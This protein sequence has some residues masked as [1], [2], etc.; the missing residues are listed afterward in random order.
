MTIENQNGKA[1]LIN[2]IQTV[3]APSY[4]KKL[5]EDLILAALF[6]RE[7]EGIIAARGDKVKVNQLSLGPAETLSGDKTKFN[8]KPITVNQFELTINRQTV[9][10]C[11]ITNLALLQSQPFMEDLKNEMSFQLMLKMEQ[12]ILEDYIAGM[13]AGNILNPITASD[14]DT[15][16]VS[17]AR[18]KASRAKLPPAGR[19][20]VMS[21]EYYGDMLN[22]T[23]VL[24][25]DFV[26]GEAIRSGKVPS[27]YG[28]GML[29][30]QSLTT[31]TAMFF[32][33]SCLQLAMQQGLTFDIVSQ[34]SNNKLSWLLVADFVWDMK[35]FDNARA[36]YV[37]EA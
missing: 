25:S 35:I 24:S 6:E 27:I 31:D 10:S 1:D 2:L 36:W 9:H 8:S 23:P 30:S 32:H 33:K 15:K 16:D 22:K 34:K 12:E 7:Y 20:M 28:F 21:P 19:F 5:R 17:A 3:W 26:S 13:A 11:E 37:K 18:V 29:E 4:Y 14:F